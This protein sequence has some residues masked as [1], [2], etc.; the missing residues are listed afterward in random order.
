[1]LRAELEMLGQLKDKAIG[2]KQ[3]W[4]DAG[5]ALGMHETTEGIRMAN[6]GG[7]G[8]VRNQNTTGG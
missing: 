8:N 4:A 1:M 2:G 7:P 3:Y 5:K 6:A